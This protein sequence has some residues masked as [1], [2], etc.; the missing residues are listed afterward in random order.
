M[1]PYMKRFLLSLLCLASTAFTQ[2]PSPTPS[3]PAPLDPL[4]TAPSVWETPQLVESN[5]ALGFRWVSVAHDSAQSTLKNATLFG[6]PVCQTLVSFD[7]EKIKEI[8]VLFYNRGDMGEIDR[9]QYEKLIQDLV[10]TIS[11]TTKTAFVARGKDAAN[12]VKVNGV[13]WNTA[14]SVYSLEYS[15]TR[16][17]QMPF[18]SE[19]VR[20][21]ITPAEKPKSLL[22]RSFAASNKEIFVAAKHVTCDAASGDVSIKDIPMVD[23]GPKGY[24]VVATAERVLRYYGIKADENELAQLAN[25]SAAGGTNVRA[26]TESLKKLGARFKI[27]VRTLFELDFNAL[28]GEYNQKARHAKESSV[29]PYSE[30]TKDFYRLIYGQ[31]KPDLLRDAR[32]KNRSGLATFQRQV[33][34]HI[35]T[36][37]PVLWSV[38]VGVLPDGSKAKAPSGH[39]RLIIGYNEK[40]GEILFSD[41]WGIGHELKRMPTVDAWAITHTLATV[42]P[43]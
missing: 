4:L 25:S 14:A 2:T 9:V 30:E 20:L 38:V 5:H 7:H 16:T 24:C 15:C 13:A 42:E 36:G 29:N 11:T 33:K 21:R 34:T 22:E 37:I 8:V 35:D 40:T 1:T 28:I 39:I 43:L 32:T 12:A 41:S 10:H 19:F 23:Q 6:Q 18:R 26:M 3:A 27:R 17:P 31:M